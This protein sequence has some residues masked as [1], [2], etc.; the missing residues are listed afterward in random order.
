MDSRAFLKELREEVGRT[1]GVG[2]SILGRMTVDP[3]A[4]ADFRIIAEQHYPLVTVFTRY[5]ELL[6]LAAPDSEAKSWL[7]KVLVDEYGEG[8]RGL[9]HAALYRNFLVATGVAPGEERSARLHPNVVE[10]VFEHLRLCTREP[11]LVGLG[12]VGPGHEWAIPTMF[13]RIIA[14]L[15]AAGFR[16]D[17]IEYFLLHVKQDQD[18]GAWLEEALA[19]SATTPENQ[20]AIRRGALA[21]L[22][23]RE[24]FWWGV[25]DKL[26]GRRMREHTGLAPST[27]GSEASEITLDQL[28]ARIKPMVSF[29]GAE[30]A[31]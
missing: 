29:A 2:H 6:L 7:A 23:A 16:D 24:Q 11:F 27:A 25:A 21:S 20:A 1:A 19:R 30:G 9:D 8:S 17:E 15:R 5:L 31:R 3:R 28:H 4:R 12:A 10:F 18:H 22:A 13:D 14:G 26:N